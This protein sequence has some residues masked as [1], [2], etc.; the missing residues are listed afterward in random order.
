MLAGRSLPIMLSSAALFATWFGS[1]TVFGASSEFIKGGLYSVIEDPFGAA[2]CLVLFGLLFA[3]KLY[4]MNLLTLGDFFKVRF[5]RRTEM[6]ASIFLAPPYVGYIAAQLVAM[7]LILN[8]VAGLAVWEGVVISA[9]VV[10]FYTY[11]GGMWAIS[12]TDF[13]Q[14]ILTI[15]GLFVLAA[16]LAK[17]AGGGGTKLRQI[18]AQKL[19]ILTEF[20]FKKIWV[21]FSAAPVFGIRS[22][23]SA[24]C[25]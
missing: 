25:F 5:G 15:T 14:S 3:R 16:I 7:G 13:F 8:A 2:L 24:D 9:F 18:S 22:I 6:V 20:Y 23:P 10:T 11:V 4:G 1:E 21:Y 12:V 19:K 17:E